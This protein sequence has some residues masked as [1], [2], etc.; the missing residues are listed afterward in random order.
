MKI[1]WKNKRFTGTNY[2]GGRINRPYLGAFKESGELWA[3]IEPHRPVG[4]FDKGK[5]ASLTFHSYQKGLK[6]RYFVTKKAAQK[7][8]EKKATRFMSLQEAI[9]KAYGI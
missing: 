1:T 8:V 3:S 6:S 4:N 2:L 7:H 5:F 9:G